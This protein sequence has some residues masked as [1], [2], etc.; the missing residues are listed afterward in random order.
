MRGNIV[1]ATLFV[2]FLASI[3]T[4]DYIP[5]YVWNRQASW[6]GGTGDGTTNGNPNLDSMGNPAW[7]YIALAG[8][9]LDSS[10]PWYTDTTPSVLGSYDT[11]SYGWVG[12][13]AYAFEDRFYHQHGG[14]A[15]PGVEW[16]NPTNE[17]I[18]VSIDGTMQFAWEQGAPNPID[19]VIAIENL[20]THATT[21]LLQ[22]TVSPS[23]N[24]LVSI[25]IPDLALTPDEG[26]LFTYRAEGGS[27]GLY[28]GYDSVDITLDSVP[29]LAIKNI[30][31]VIF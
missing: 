21:M 20:Q 4:A 23:G 17:S 12:G 11:G 2:G 15:A 18:M 9:G 25:A 28:T 30:R 13:D 14:P 1:L 29:M 19:Y 27:V 6:Y 22:T 24:P 7:E 16:L 10:N 3:A 31:K 5:G 26:L 8:G